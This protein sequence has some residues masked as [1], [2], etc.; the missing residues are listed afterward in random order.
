M[1][2]YMDSNTRKLYSSASKDGKNVYNK[3]NK[4]INKLALSFFHYINLIYFWLVSSIED[5][6]LG[7]TLVH[8]FYELIFSLTPLLLKIFPH[9]AVH[10]KGLSRKEG[11]V[12]C[13]L[14]RGMARGCWETAQFTKAHWVNPQKEQ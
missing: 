14:A 1:R 10:P 6:L 8:S 4:W 2:G 5:F 9:I 3:Q 13:K 7:V 11:K 12:S